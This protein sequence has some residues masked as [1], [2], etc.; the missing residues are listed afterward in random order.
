MKTRVQELADISCLRYVV[1]ATKP[2]H[3]LKIHP[4]VHN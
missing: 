2:M 3:R 1:I 4:T